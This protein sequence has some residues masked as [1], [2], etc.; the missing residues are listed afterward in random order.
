[1]KKPYKRFLA[2]VLAFAL[3]GIL[4][5]AVVLAGELV[6]T[7]IVAD[8]PNGAITVRQGETVNFKI[9]LEVN[10]GI[11]SCT[12][13][14][15]GNVKVDTSYNVVGTSISSNNSSATYQFY[16]GGT[17]SYLVDATA[18]AD[19]NAVP[20]TYLT[21]I[22][23]IYTNP[24][25]QGE[26]L[27]NN[28]TDSLKIIVIP[29][30]TAPPE[31]KIT[32]PVNG[33]Y[34]RTDTVPQ[35]KYSASDNVDGI[36]PSE[37]C[38]ISGWNT[39]EEGKHEV[40]V[41][42]TDAA[43]NT[44][45]NTI[46]YYIDNTPPTVNITSPE[47]NQFLKTMPEVT[48]TK[49]SDVVYISSED[50]VNELGIHTYTITA[51]DSAGNIG[52]ASVTF[53]IDS[54]DPIV[55]I[56]NPLNGEFYKTDSLPDSVNYSVDDA[57]TDTSYI[58]G[59]VKGFEGLHTVTVSA[60]DKAGNTGT[61]SATYTVDNTAPV[62]S[63]N[64]PGNG[65]FK[66]MN[67]PN[68]SVTAEDN[69]DNNP[70][71]TRPEALKSAEGT[72]TYTITA[73]DSAGN[74]T[75]QN[76]TYTI[77]NTKPSLTVREP[78]EGK[79]YK[80]SDLPEEVLYTANDN[81]GLS[82]KVEA[83]GFD[84]TEG[85]HAVTITATD[86]AGNVETKIINYKV[87]NTPPEVIITNIVEGKFYRT[88]DLPEMIV[89]D[90][91][92]N[93]VEN[94][95]VEASMLIKTEGRHSLTVTATDTAGNIRSKTVSYIV[96]NT[97][98]VVESQ[99]RGAVYLVNEVVKSDWKVTDNL[100]GISSTKGSIEKGQNIDTSSVGIKNYTVAATD[101]AGNE[102]V[103]TITYK[104]VYVF[105]GILQPIINNKSI[106]KLGSVIPVK[107]QLKDL[108]GNI[109]T[110]EIGERPTI[111]L[112]KIT[113]DILNGEMSEPYSV[114]ASLGN[115]FRFDESSNQYIFNLNTKFME[116]GT[117]DITIDLKDGSEPQIVRISSR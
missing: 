14:N 30:D 97:A 40:K 109:I 87:D 1:M 31:V 8:V 63:I 4:Q 22:H 42:A 29:K 85:T 2:V 11:S 90:C 105:G 107:F 108:S 25:A 92:D 6:A 15:P 57:N 48:F 82:P 74:I 32:S 36:I 65:Y 114:M 16:E 20:G 113:T 111:G 35:L 116:K 78:V 46:V 10:G 86:A 49:S 18:S 72:H 67:L 17:T 55:N 69:Y 98:P 7:E 101:R 80:S 37:K 115:E 52:E 83:S 73:V 5:V 77:D 56:L 50:V 33:E 70:R 19:M 110:K 59:Y 95:I 103:Q 60:T 66:S 38:Q 24:Y 21:R 61:A 84:K 34:Y 96:D 93:D 51:K 12:K 43:G 68:L 79:I 9:K 89:Y 75:S 39:T 26:K 47:N 27:A 102:I 13:Q 54:I 104:V 88:T 53:T 76:I 112:M 100:S 91:K 23:I 81:S 41:T 3:T 94:P 28:T 62:L 117:Y 99:N 106:F 71:I 45:T 64:F 44:G 58:S